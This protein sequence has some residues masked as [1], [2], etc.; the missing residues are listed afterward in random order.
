M[1][2]P[3]DELGTNLKENQI[4]LVINNSD[5]LTIFENNS[6]NDD[7]ESFHLFGSGRAYQMG[8]PD[9]LWTLGAGLNNQSFNISFPQLDK[10]GKV[11]IFRSNFILLKPYGWY[12]VDTVTYYTQHYSANDEIMNKRKTG[13]INI[14]H[15]NN[16]SI[17]FEGTFDFWC[18]GYYINQG[19]MKPLN[20]SLRISGSF[21]YY[22]SRKTE[23]PANE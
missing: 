18:F 5:S 20:D 15:I 3:T 17:E 16:D 14:T 1:P 7:Y 23:L 4:K 11:D 22:R 2:T 8:L 21:S 10:P 9:T 12:A 6:L 13:E 19:K